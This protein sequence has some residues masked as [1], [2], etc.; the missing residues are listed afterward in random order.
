MSDFSELEVRMSTYFKGTNL[1]SRTGFSEIG[2]RRVPI[3]YLPKILP[4]MGGIKTKVGP[5]R[6]V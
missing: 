1:A 5:D 6:R 2:V 3:W 4:K